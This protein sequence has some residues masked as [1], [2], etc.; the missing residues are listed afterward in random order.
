MIFVALLWAKSILVQYVRALFM[1]LPYL[2]SF[3][4]EAIWLV[5]ALVFA[6][7]IHSFLQRVFVKDALYILGCLLIFLLHYLIYPLNREYY[8]KYADLF[9]ESALPMYFV[10]ISLYHKKSEKQIDILYYVSLATVLAFTVYNLLLSSIDE[11]TLKDGDMYA[12]YNLLPHVC[13]V[14]G[15]VMKKPNPLNIVTF[16]IGCFMQI[17][18]GTRGAILCLAI[19]VVLCIL[20]A[21]KMKYP[22][23]FAVISLGAAVLAI[24]GGLL[25]LL[26]DFAEKN[27]LSLRFFDKLMNGEITNS[28]GRDQ[29]TERVSEYISY[30]PL[31]GCGIYSDRRVADGQYAHNVALELMIDFGV[32]FGTLILLAIVALFLR[33][34][35][36]LRKKEDVRAVVLF[37]SLLCSS[38]FRLFLSGSYLTERALYLLVGFCV[39]VLRDKSRNTK[40]SQNSAVKSRY[41]NFGNALRRKL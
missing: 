11:A 12:A 6:F 22:F 2:W 39:A 8:T 18:M 36:Y 41:I 4:D 3:A 7:S 26:Y 20:F 16:V 21:R 9:V 29:I 1:Q 34:F 14:F 33:T 27:N 35:L 28:S 31:T 38:F 37:L 19:Y 30:Y 40:P 13:L 17:S 24:Y 15:Y 10:G 5:F 32:I 25:D 23:L